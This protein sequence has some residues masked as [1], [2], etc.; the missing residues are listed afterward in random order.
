MT[1][2]TGKSWMAIGETDD[3]NVIIES[4]EAAAQITKGESKQNDHKT[5]IYQTRGIAPKMAQH[6][7]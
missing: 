5:R 3:P 2:L 7:G 4:Y 1:D 6:L